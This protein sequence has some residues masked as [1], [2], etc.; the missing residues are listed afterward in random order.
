MQILK[1]KHWT[2]PGDPSG[3]VWGRAER[4]EGDFN[5]IGRTKVKIK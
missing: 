2:R 5:L 1:A 4:H 3:R